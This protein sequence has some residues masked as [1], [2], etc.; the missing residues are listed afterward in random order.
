MDTH[1][2]KRTRVH[3]CFTGHIA[4]GDER[5]P[6]HTENI[7]LKGMLCI[8]EAPLPPGRACLVEIKLAEDVRLRIEARTVRME[9]NAVGVDFVS[10]DE[11]S[12]RHLR[13]IVRLAADDPD[14]ID[15]E[16]SIPAFS[17]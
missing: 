15:K 3:G 8:P 16:Q 4:I 14:D 9:H 12:Y 1:Q 13:N 10:M 7:S 2:R 6:F 17:D 5:T 11:E